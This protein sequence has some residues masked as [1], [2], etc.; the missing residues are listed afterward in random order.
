MLSVRFEGGNLGRQ[1]GVMKAR[2][3]LFPASSPIPIAALNQR[4][5]RDRG[6]VGA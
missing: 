2:G 4:E 5:R 1:R 6:G 3:A